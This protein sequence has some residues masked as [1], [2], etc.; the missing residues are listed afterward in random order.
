[1]ENDGSDGDESIGDVAGSDDISEVSISTGSNK[2][3]LSD[4]IMH[5]I[6]D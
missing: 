1:M 6:I 3:I 5:L 2:T 4:E